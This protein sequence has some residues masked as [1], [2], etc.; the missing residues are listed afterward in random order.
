MKAARVLLN[1]RTGDLMEGYRVSLFDK[2]PMLHSKL[3][4]SIS[5]KSLLFSLTANVK[6]GLRI[7]GN[8]EF[9][10]SIFLRNKT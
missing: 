8:Y 4:Y 1:V 5:L 7:W 3:K 10:K 6:S 9:Y 2:K